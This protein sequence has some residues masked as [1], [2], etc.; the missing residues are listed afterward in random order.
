[1]DTQMDQEKGLK[2]IVDQLI[3]GVFFNLRATIA[4][5]GSFFNQ[6]NTLISG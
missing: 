2:S 3:E 4:F 1:M 6:T 5:F